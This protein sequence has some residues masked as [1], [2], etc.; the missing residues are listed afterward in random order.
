MRPD[1][2]EFAAGKTRQHF[3]L[4]TY[5]LAQV[6]DL[7][8][9]LNDSVQGLLGRCFDD[10]FLRMWD[11]Y[12]GSCEATFLERHTGLFQ[13]V[14]LKNGAQRVLFIEPWSDA[15]SSDAAGASQ[16]AA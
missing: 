9:D 5:D 7:L 13:L 4:R 1:Q 16:S 15:A 10:R 12:L 14:L 11:L 2:L 3:A 8:L 6:K